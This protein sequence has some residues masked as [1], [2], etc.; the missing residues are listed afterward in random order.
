[1]AKRVIWD[2]H[3]KRELKK[4]YP[5]YTAKYLAEY[6]RVTDRTIYAKAK[7]LGILKG[8]EVTQFKSGKNNIMKDLNIIKKVHLSRKI[9]IN[10]DKARIKWGLPQKTKMKLNLK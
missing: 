5:K 1:M 2:Y 6:F 7:E 9:A 3:K 10:N 4:L 8:S